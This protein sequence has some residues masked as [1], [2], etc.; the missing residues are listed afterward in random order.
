LAPPLHCTS[1]LPYPAALPESDDTID[2]GLLPRSAPFVLWWRGHLDPS[3]G[4]QCIVF[5]RS[6]RN[7]V[8]GGG[9]DLDHPLGIFTGYL[10][11]D[12]EVGGS[13]PPSCTIKINNLAAGRLTM[14]CWVSALCPCSGCGPAHET[15]PKKSCRKADERKGSP[16]S[17][18]HEMRSFGAERTADRHRRYALLLYRSSREIAI[19]GKA[20]S[21]WTSR[22]IT[23]HEAGL[24][25]PPE[26]P[27]TRTE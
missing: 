20:A 9:S 25:R 12:Q 27:F 1:R 5:R 2:R 22:R 8:S 7:I 4:A 17:R 21:K 15:P 19:C 6:L 11:V 26:P 23:W 3:P 14:K 13:N 16:S 24:A 18:K 10:T